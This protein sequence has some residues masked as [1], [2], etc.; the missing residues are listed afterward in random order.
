VF[1]LFEALRNNAF[2]GI[3]FRGALG[4]DIFDFLAYFGLR[5]DTHRRYF[6]HQGA[7]ILRRNCGRMLGA[8]MM[9]F[10][11]LPPPRETVQARGVGLARGRD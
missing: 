10:W 6:G 5:W 4:D 3:A 9:D 7:F 1:Y 8:K 2:S 11:D